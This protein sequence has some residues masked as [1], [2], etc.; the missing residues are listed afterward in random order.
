V[1]KMRIAYLRT[2]NLVDTGTP[3]VNPEEVYLPPLY[4]K[5]GR[6]K[7]VVIAVNQNS[8]GFMYLKN[9]SHNQ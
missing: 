8:A 6:I 9:V 3:L 1:A 5:L 4:I 7:N 2:K